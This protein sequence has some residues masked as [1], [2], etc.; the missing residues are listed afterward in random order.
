MPDL[1]QL[2]AEQRR[3]LL[4]RE[5]GVLAAIAR[6]YAA[7]AATLAARAAALAG[8][9]QGVST[10]LRLAH[11]ATLTA[12]IELQLQRIATEFVSRIEVERQAVIIEAAGDWQQL[13]AAIG[14]EPGLDV[15]AA[16]RI[17]AA[18][19]PGTPLSRL[20]AEASAAGVEAAKQ[21]LFTGVVLGDNPTRIGARIRSALEISRARAQTIARTETLRAYRGAIRERMK[22]AN[23][24]VG[25]VWIAAR[26]RR[27]CPMC[28]AMHGTKHR[29]DELMGTHPNCR[30]SQ[31]PLAAN[32]YVD[33]PPGSQVFARLPGATQRD[34]LGPAKYVAYQRGAISL[35]DVVGEVQSPTWGL[36]RYERSLADIVG[37]DQARA[38]RV[39]S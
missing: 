28:W 8:E 25:W 11:M 12:Q 29:L 39:A 36:V 30:C 34:I 17:Q 5:Q 13:A 26:D 23:G 20:L 24:V 32:S 16:E 19:A 9:P 15:T 38:L 27:T 21:A 22:Q 33:V 6:R 10:Q 35:Q 3:R 1:E 18:L 7:A 2:I 4:Q 14:I 31:A 37:S